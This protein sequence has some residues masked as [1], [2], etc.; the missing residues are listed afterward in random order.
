M[1]SVCSY[2]RLTIIK[3]CI[4][5]SWGDFCRSLRFHS[6]WI[7]VQKV[8]I[9]CSV[10]CQQTFPWFTNNRHSYSGTY[11]ETRQTY[12]F[13]YPS[14]VLT[15]DWAHCGLSAT[16]P[17]TTYCSSLNDTSVSS[18]L[19]TVYFKGSGTSIMYN[20]SRRAATT[21]WTCSSSSTMNVNCIL[22][23]HAKTISSSHSYCCIYDTCDKNLKVFT[24]FRWQW[25]LWPGANF[26][27]DK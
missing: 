17:T 27:C 23:L 18:S 8:Q 6:C 13:F 2:L 9:F 12:W 25:C 24:V 3:C 1:K 10:H 19:K 26:Y 20:H 14:E 7:F 22:K 16:L 5:S 4:L 11:P 15:L 21:H